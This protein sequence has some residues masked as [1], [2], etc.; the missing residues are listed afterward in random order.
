MLDVSA[1][2]VVF[3]GKFKKSFKKAEAHRALFR[4][5]EACGV[6]HGDRV[7]GLGDPHRRFFAGGECGVQAAV[8]V[9]VVAGDR[10]D[11][12]A[13]ESLLK[14]ASSA[15]D[16]FAKVRDV[17]VGFAGGA[18]PEA[19]GPRRVPVKPDRRF[20]SLRGR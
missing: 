11:A 1:W 17:W 20:R 9:G 10:F 8:V 19:G 14:A 12:D 6:E 16:A 2:K 15:N 13:D 4:I 18:G 3:E 5:A 7:Q